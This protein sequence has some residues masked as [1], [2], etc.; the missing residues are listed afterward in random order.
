MGDR[1]RER[2]RK[3]RERVTQTHIVMGWEESKREREVIYDLGKQQQK[4]ARIKRIRYASHLSK[5]KKC[6]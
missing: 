2:Q 5:S 1:Q 3:E 4:M 6:I